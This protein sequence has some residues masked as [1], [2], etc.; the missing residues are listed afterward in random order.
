MRGEVSLKDLVGCVRSLG[1][2]GLSQERFLT[3][4]GGQPGL[5]VCRSGEDR[6]G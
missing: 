4:G 1:A 6:P 5:T 2:E 3:D